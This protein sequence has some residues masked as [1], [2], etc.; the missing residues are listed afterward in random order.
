MSSFEW[1]LSQPDTFGSV[2]VAELQ[3]LSD[4]LPDVVY[5]GCPPTAP[6]ELLDGFHNWGAA[7]EP[8]VNLAQAAIEAASQV[9][10]LKKIGFMLL[11][12]TLEP[13]KHGSNP[14]MWHAGDDTALLLSSAPT[15]EFAVGAI[16]VP[17]GSKV[18]RLISSSATLIPEEPDLDK[19]GVRVFSPN[20]GEFTLLK[21]TDVHR[22]PKNRTDSPIDRLFIKFDIVSSRRLVIARQRNIYKVA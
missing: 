7:R 20:P 19:D 18:V 2:D 1:R 5:N 8:M 6:A 14:S 21:F 10:S 16:K 22:A 4:V 9:M 15:T 13:E 12:E 17:K 11:K 3:A